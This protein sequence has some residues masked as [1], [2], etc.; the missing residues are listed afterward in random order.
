[1]A[2]QDH[3]LLDQAKTKSGLSARAYHRILKVI[4][5]IADLDGADTIRTPHLSEAISYR[6]LDQLLTNE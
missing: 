4:C 5:T 3:A 2:A 6:T 1:L